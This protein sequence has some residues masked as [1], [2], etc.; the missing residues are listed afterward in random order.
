MGDRGPA[1]DPLQAAKG[2]PGRRR[3]K[4]KA[5]A[6]AAA[7][8]TALLAPAPAG[9][10]ELPPILQ[11]PKYAPAAAI[12]RRLAPELRRTHRLPPESEFHLV[13]T[14]IYTQ[15]WAAATEDLHTRGFVQEIETIA[16]G[17]ME[18]RRPKVFDRQQAFQNLMELSARFGLTPMDLY[19]LFKDQ[20]VV[21]AKNPGLFDEARRST[22]APP[23]A[24]P[25]PTE[26]GDPEP[27]PAGLIGSFDRMRSQ[28]PGR[29][30]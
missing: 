7:H 27:R 5:A 6:E 8:L 20:A 21:A 13:Q 9:A 29:P 24:P 11:D 3:S 26:A 15:E 12:W 17:K 1:P 10:A 30:N 22:G 16:G 23:P 19:A 25:P 28:P 18:R 2:N 4:A 14:C